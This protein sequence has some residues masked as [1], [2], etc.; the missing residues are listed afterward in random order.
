M[1]LR[2]SG[3]TQVELT[4]VDAL[5]QQELLQCEADKGALSRQPNESK[6]GS[7]DL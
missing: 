2:V 4:C 5:L 6:A 3:E 7:F 1:S